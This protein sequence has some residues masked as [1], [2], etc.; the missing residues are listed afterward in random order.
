[1]PVTAIKKWTK[2]LIQG[3]FFTSIELGQ[4][5]NNKFSLAASLDFT[6]YDGEAGPNVV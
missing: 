3:T 1:M 5:I 4:H 6:S 2:T